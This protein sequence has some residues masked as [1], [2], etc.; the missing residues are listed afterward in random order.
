[1]DNS[2]IFRLRTLKCTKLVLECQLRSLQQFK[3]PNQ[4]Q[5][6]QKIIVRFMPFERKL[7]NDLAHACLEPGVLQ[8]AAHPATNDL[9]FVARVLF[10]RWS[11]ASDVY[12]QILT[13]LNPFDVAED[14]NGSQAEA[15]EMAMTMVRNTID[16]SSDDQRFSRTKQ[17]IT[18]NQQFID[19]LEHVDREMI[20]AVPREDDELVWRLLAVM[21]QEDYKTIGYW[22]G[23]SGVVDQPKSNELESEA[24]GQ[25]ALLDHAGAEDHV[26][27]L[28]DLADAVPEAPT[29]DPLEEDAQN[30][31]DQL[32]DVTNIWNVWEFCRMYRLAKQRPQNSDSISPMLSSDV[33]QKSWKLINIAG[34]SDDSWQGIF[35][36]EKYEG[37]Q[38][39]R[40]AVLN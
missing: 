27:Q 18:D 34:E 20:D 36:R 11:W 19:A 1:M 21:F 8:Q 30:Q 37:E 23:F 29:E 26:G 6:R 38:L 25:D 24:I 2:L 14:H 3:E 16:T 13:D 4:E 10:F 7:I 17:F 12:R 9:D 22:P 35:P 5:M 31:V 28:P 32:M 39:V 15:F 33:F 40:N